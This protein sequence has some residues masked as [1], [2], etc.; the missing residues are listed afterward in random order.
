MVHD[1]VR[2][3]S[4]SGT[5]RSLTIHAGIHIRKREVLMYGLCRNTV[6]EI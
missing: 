2:D 5:G 3:R 6:G 1:S 4:F